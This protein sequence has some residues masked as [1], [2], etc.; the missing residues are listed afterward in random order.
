M[1]MDNNEADKREGV[2]P[3]YKKYKGFGP[4]QMTREGFIGF[5]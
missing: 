2:M 3:A 4:L 1:G 5:F